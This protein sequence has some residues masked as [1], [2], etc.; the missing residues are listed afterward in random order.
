MELISMHSSTDNAKP[1]HKDP[2]GKLPEPPKCKGKTFWMILLMIIISFFM[3][4]LEGVAVGNA[5]LTI[6]G[7]L[8]IEQFIWIST[9][10]GLTSTALLPLSGRLVQIFSCCLVM[11]T[12]LVVF[13][14]N[15]AISGAVNGAG[16]LFAGCRSWWWWHAD[17]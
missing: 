4:I 8:N 5:L 12:F 9:A 13:A 16:T 6:T 15:G 14:V 17:L 11:L 10:Y 3:V 7:D 2:N 1:I